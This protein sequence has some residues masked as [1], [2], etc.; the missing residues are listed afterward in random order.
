MA[1]RKPKPKAAKAADMRDVIR[2]KCG[3]AQTF[4]DDGAYYF[5]SRVLA[6]LAETVKAHAV[7]ADEALQ[8]FILRKRA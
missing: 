3:L 5:A 8:K 2:E 4:A 1:N 6:E 7:S